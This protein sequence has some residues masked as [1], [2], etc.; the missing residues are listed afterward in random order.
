MPDQPE[1]IVPLDP[2]AGQRQLRGE[3]LGTPGGSFVEIRSYEKPDDKKEGN[4]DDNHLVDEE[5]PEDEAFP[6]DEESLEDQ[7]P[8][9]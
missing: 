7:G 3:S 5:P 9:N 1:L 4:L 2:D 8:P 6:E